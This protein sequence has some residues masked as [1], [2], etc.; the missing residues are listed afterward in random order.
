MI[1]TP[2]SRRIRRPL[3]LLGVGLL[4]A[5]VVCMIV[6]FPMERLAYRNSA[7]L[8]PLITA[9][10]VSFL[11]QTLAMIVWGRNYH[12]PQLISTTPMQ[13]IEG[14]SSTRSR[15]PPSSPRPSSW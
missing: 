9:I 3:L 10:G 2:G 7:R 5:M 1:S 13:P 15:S 6:A 11:L 8:A 4:A 14:Y 12:L